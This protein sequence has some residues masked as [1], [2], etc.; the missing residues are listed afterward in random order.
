MAANTYTTTQG[1]AWD[2]I[3]YRLFG[4]ERLA[5][6]LMQANPEHMDVLMF[7]AGVLLTVPKVAPPQQALKLP[8]WSQSH[9]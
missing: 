7:P 3:A 8:P 9:E 4:E 6:L 1:D 2:T 5:H